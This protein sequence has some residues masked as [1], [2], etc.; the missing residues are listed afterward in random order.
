MLLDL[1]VV[2]MGEVVVGTPCRDASTIL[3]SS[4]ALTWDEVWGVPSACGVEE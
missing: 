4:R 1:V 3:T 2:A